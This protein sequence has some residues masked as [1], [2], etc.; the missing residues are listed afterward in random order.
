MMF[1]LLAIFVFVVPR[2]TTVY[3]DFGTPLPL[4]TTLMIAVGRFMQTP[5]G[6]L[7][8]VVVAFGVAA[9]ASFAPIRGRWLRLALVVLFALLILGLALAVLLPMLNLME[10]ISKNPGKM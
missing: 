5:L 3:T 6:W 1:V 9:V 2:L 7:C 8:G 4:V 10:S